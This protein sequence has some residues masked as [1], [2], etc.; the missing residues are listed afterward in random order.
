MMTSMMRP[1]IKRIVFATIVGIA[2]LLPA[3]ARAQGAIPQPC[4]DGT[5]PSGA[6]LHIG[7]FGIHQRH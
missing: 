3:P 2:V 5:L 6:F 7:R 4:V 1:M